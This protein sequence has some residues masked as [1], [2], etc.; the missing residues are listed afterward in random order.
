MTSQTRGLWLVMTLGVLTITAP[1]CAQENLDQG[2]TGQQ[3]FASDCAICHKGPQGLAAK[4]GNGL[5]G[6]DSFLREHYTASRQT[7]AVLAKYLQSVGDAPA[8]DSKRGSS[9]RAAKPAEKKPDETKKSESKPDAKSEAKSESKSESKSDAKSE[10]KNEAKGETKPEAK[11]Q[12]KPDAD[13][14][15][16]SE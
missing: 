16:K 7:A 14:P 13:K 11:P 12:Q 15:A 5:F 1:A 8:A 3:I 6:L 9:R 2:K 4:A 10:A